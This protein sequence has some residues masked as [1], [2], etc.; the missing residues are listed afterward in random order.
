MVEY[1]SPLDSNNKY[2]LF[3]VGDDYKLDLDVK[4]LLGHRTKIK[5]PEK[6][7]NIIINIINDFFRNKLVY[8]NYIRYDLP[9]KPKID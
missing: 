9:N 5:D 1:V 4:T 8:P 6:L 2:I 3:S 7:T